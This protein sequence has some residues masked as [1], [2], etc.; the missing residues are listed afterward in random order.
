[1]LSIR[2]F[3]KIVR[4]YIFLPVLLLTPA[5]QPNLTLLETIQQ[6]GEL[7]VATQ[8]G[9]TTYFQAHGQ[10]TG[11]EYE[12]ARQFAD[13]LGV[14]LKIVKSNDEK[15]LLS[16]LKSGK[17]HAA[18]GLAMTPV[19]SKEFL[20]SAPYQEVT[21][22]LV[23]KIGTQNPKSIAEIGNGKL[24]IMANSSHADYLEKVKPDF[25]GLTWEEVY[26][27]TAL[28][29]LTMIHE[30]K[31]DYTIINSNVL[32]AHQS[33]FPELRAAFDITQP[34]PLAWAFRHSND[35]SLVLSAHTFFQGAQKAGTLEELKMRF[36]SH[37][38]FDYVDARTFL[39]HIDK[40]LP[41]YKKTFKT[42]ATENG[43]DW[44]LLAAIGYQESLW[45]P[46]AI[47]RTGVRGL[48]M[49]TRKTA[50]EMGIS[51]RRNAEQS[52]IGGAAYFKKLYLRFPDSIRNTHRIW[53]TLAAYN[54]GFGHVMDARDITARQGGSADNWFEVKEILPL[55]K[56]PEYYRKSKYGYTRGGEQSVAYVRQ[57][58]RYYESLVWATTI[59]QNK[60]VPLPQNVI[61]MSDDTDNPDGS[62]LV[63]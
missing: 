27:A 52:I 55:L 1:M 34:E 56:S 17:A 7:V 24:V 31:A 47:S 3:Y 51:N 43:L 5:C 29:I 14:A 35:H 57:V 26:G 60:F 37:Q 15:E 23:F 59:E 32:D 40:R 48:M 44:R 13:F 12:L 33:V 9:P 2:L 39:R 6:T 18:A 49:L 36:Y 46:N 10:S 62:T 16:L 25:P 21:Q 30:G 50:S 22:Q 19:R 4:L 58:R 61:A 45:N 11:L 38:L 41:K 54:V 53:F 28:D 20:F 8:S 63:Y 42:A